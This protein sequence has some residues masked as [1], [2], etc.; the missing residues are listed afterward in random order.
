MYLE[1]EIY[2]CDLTNMLIIKQNLS[3]TSNA[4]IKLSVVRNNIDKK[5]IQ[6]CYGLKLDETE[7]RYLFVIINI[8]QNLNYEFVRNGMLIF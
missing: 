3:N 8:N 4:M 2:I 6:K 5:F 7:I 1:K